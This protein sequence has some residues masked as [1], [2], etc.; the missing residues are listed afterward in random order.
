MI[1]VL[2]LFF[3]AY[4]NARMI[5]SPSKTVRNE[6]SSAEMYPALTEEANLDEDGETIDEINQKQGVGEVLYQGDIVL[7]DEQLNEI[8]KSREGATRKERQAF[9]DRNYPGT[10]WPN[11]AVYYSFHHST[12]RKLQQL[13]RKGAMEWQKQTCLTF[14]E[15]RDANDRIEL[16]ANDGCWSYVGNMHKVQPLSLGRGCETIGTAAHEIGHA[17]GMFHT[18]SR[19]DRDRYIRIDKQNIRPIFL[20]QFQKETESTNDNYGLPY[21]YGSLMHYGARSFSSN[22]GITMMP[23]NE[24]YIYTMGSPFLSF[25]DLLMMNKHYNCFGKCQGKSFAARCA[26][27]GFPNPR[28]CSKCVC[29]GGY[30]GKLC[31]ER[32]AGCGRIL[33][34]TTSF[35]PFADIVGDRSVTYTNQRDD[36]LICNYWIKVP[37]GKRIEIRFVNITNGVAKNGCYWAGVE[38]KVQKDQRLTGYR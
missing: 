29:P 6:H 14:F 3:A 20:G 7:N 15:K 16:I 10:I 33:K 1:L 23:Y 36:F 13:F 30:G 27:G 19:H 28:D 18:Q 21:D 34:A 12:N 22:G 31:I 17:L 5:I 8:M 11:G 32:P 26:M 2:Y 24:N 25:Y 38:L 9:K 37:A 35:R 4:A